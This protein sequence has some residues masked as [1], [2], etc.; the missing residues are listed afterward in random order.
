MSKS[1]WTGDRG[2]HP[3]RLYLQCLTLR[4]IV[5]FRLWGPSLSLLMT[6]RVSL[7]TYQVSPYT[8]QVRIDRSWNCSPESGK[9]NGKSQFHPWHFWLV[10]LSQLAPSS[11][12]RLLT[13]LSFLVT[14][15]FHFSLALPCSIPPGPRTAPFLIYRGIFFP[16][17]TKLPFCSVFFK[18]YPGAICC[19]SY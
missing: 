13:S 10:S 2:L 16:L 15:R 3:Q 7:F 12:P 4:W 8:W 14:Y 18:N 19:S 6:A 1:T 17:Y 11:S 9:E 5:L